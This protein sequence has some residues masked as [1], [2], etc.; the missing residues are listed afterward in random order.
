MSLQAHWTN[1]EEKN[2]PTATRFVELAHEKGF[3]PP[4]VMAAII[5]DWLKIAYASVCAPDPERSEDL[6][7]TR[8]LG[9]H[10]SAIHRTCSG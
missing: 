2:G 10:P 8:Q 5:V 9:R 3:D 7:E 4:D 1:S 6:R